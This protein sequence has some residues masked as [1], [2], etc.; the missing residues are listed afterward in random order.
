V[1][2]K[3]IHSDQRNHHQRD[4]RAAAWLSMG[5][6]LLML[7]G[8]TSAYL[9]TGSAAILSDA[10]ES[11][12]HVAATVMALYSVTYSGKPADRCHPY[13]HGKIE[14]FSAGIEG[15]FIILAAGAIY[16][17]VIRGL[18]EGRQLQSLN[19]G[20]AVVGAAAVVNFLLGW[21]LIH[22][23]NTRRSLTLTADGK[24][25]LTDAYTSIGVFIGVF[26]VKWTGLQWFDPLVAIVVATNI[27]WTGWRLIRQSVGG[28]MDE[29]DVTALNTVVDKLQTDR[30]PGWI[31]VHRLRMIKSGDT[32]HVDFHMTVPRYW[33]I[34]KGHETE[35]QVAA[36]VK[37]AFEG[38]A[39]VIVHLD[40]CMPSCCILCTVD[41][42]P[43][44]EANLVNRPTW[45]VEHA[46]KPADY[47]E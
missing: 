14:F 23:G 32:H 36:A 13:G 47:I 38:Y 6:G 43:M 22:V 11:V 26:L 16:V 31:D 4:R 29:A 39:E 28:L 35:D 7:L 44:R 12:V 46:E 37:D 3:P 42:C 33:D 19:I 10:L 24:H 30:R 18:I 5:V 27:V 2:E 25:V 17:E 9:I 34:A 21:Y 20:I 45:T 8:K 41:P 40:P 1:T 15:G